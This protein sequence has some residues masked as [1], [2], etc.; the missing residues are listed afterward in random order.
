MTDTCSRRLELLT[1]R[2]AGARVSDNRNGRRGTVTGVRLFY[3]AG[4][5]WWTSGLHLVV[6]LDA[7]GWMFARLKQVN[8]L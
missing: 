1:A 4:R 3:D 7:G 5:M 2:F 6:T 8:F